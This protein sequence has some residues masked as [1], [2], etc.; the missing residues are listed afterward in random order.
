MDKSGIKVRIFDI[1]NGLRE[2]KDIKIIRIISKDYN[3]LIMKDYLP[4]IGEIEGSVDI[5]NDE[6]NLSFKDIKAFYMNSNNEFNL[7]IKEG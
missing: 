1:E 5:K 4:I 6:V 2:Y 7:M 3:L